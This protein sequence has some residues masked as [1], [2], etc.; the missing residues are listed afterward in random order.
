[1]SEA[2]VW[3]DEENNRLIYTD[4]YGNEMVVCEN[5]PPTNPLLKFIDEFRG[6]KKGGH[7]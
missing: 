3:I 5:F 6:A 2:K 1:M 4:E 7:P